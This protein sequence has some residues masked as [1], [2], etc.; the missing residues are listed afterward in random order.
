M[1]IVIFGATVLVPRSSSRMNALSN[2]GRSNEGSGDW[3]LLVIG[4]A[5]AG[6]VI[7]VR[8]GAPDRRFPVRNRASDAFYL[9]VSQDWS[10][11]LLVIAVGHVW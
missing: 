3:L 10:T 6:S 9:T 2:E 8:Y 11:S 5:L 4:H 1:S 7:A